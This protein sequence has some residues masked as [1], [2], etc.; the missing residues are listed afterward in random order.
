MRS[1]CGD[2][3]VRARRTRLRSHD[4]V[5]EPRRE[6]C[7]HRLITRPLIQTAEHALEL[8]HSISLSYTIADLTK[9]IG[10]I[11]L[12]QG[13]YLG[14]AAKAEA[15]AARWFVEVGTDPSWKGRGTETW[16]PK[17]GSKAGEKGAG[18]R[19]LRPRPLLRRRDLIDLF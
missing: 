14:A 4:R 10:A 5:R 9:T 1:R 16:R 8:A 13:D 12:Q 7:G 18:G 2:R 17:H 19:N 3:R 15:E 11:Q 6:A